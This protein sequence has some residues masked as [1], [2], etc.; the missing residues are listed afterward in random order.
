MVDNE[1]AKKILACL[2]NETYRK[3]SNWQL[4]WRNSMMDRESVCKCR[5]RIDTEVQ[6][7]VC[8]TLIHVQMLTVHS[9]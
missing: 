9:V 5:Q 6:C 2:A 3:S 7:T 1:I 8:K 4:N